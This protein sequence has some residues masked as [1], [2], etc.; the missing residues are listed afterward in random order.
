MA[1]LFGVLDVARRGVAA[2]SYGVR[3]TGHNIAN[4]NTPGY[5]RQRTVLEASLPLPTGAGMLGTGVDVVSVERITD[6]FVQGQLLR[7]GSLFGASDAQAQALARVEELL[8]DRDGSGL[9]SS[10][11][12]LYDAFSDLASAATPGAPIEREQLRGVAQS[13]IDTV[14]EIDRQLRDQMAALN[15]EIEGVVPEIDRLAGEIRDLNVE[16]ARLEVE[17]PANDLRDRRD[18]ALREL[19]GLVDVRTFEDERGRLSVTLSSGLSLVEGGFQRQLAAVPDP[20]NPFDVGFSRIEYRDGAVA[21]DVT[22]QIGGGRL[23]GLLRARDAH[24]PA[25][26]RSLD[27]VA[28]NLATSVNAVHAAGVG[29]DGNVGDFFA[30]PAAVEDAA[31]SL[32]LDAAIEASPDA[33]AAGLTSAASDNRNALA[34]AALRETAAPLTLPGDP[35]GSPS[36]PTRTVLEH[37]STVI[38]DV[39]SRT[40]AMNAARSQE[41]RLLETLQNQRDQISGVS[42]DEE[43][44][45]LVEL[46]AAFRANSR[47][48]SVVDRLLEDVL[49]LL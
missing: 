20:T 14:H 7:H 6:G 30:A 42:L 29:L 5:S 3:A 40:R 27:T 22:D 2:S 31:R 13:L 38:A 48:I 12:A 25:A 1:G 44:T 9:A 19:A 4:V 15:H 21:F 17:A 28:Y 49:S 37:V 34:L 47:V 24:L 33:I 46:Q 23:G 39:G 8:A 11:S 18:E 35:L 16:I 43:V 36:G 45:H 26:V 10:L 41:E 32:A